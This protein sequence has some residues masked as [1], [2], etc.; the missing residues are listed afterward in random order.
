MRKRR[1]TPEITDI[2]WEVFCWSSFLKL[3]CMINHFKRKPFNH[4][5]HTP[6]PPQQHNTHTPSLNDVRRQ[7]LKIICSVSTKYRHPTTSL[8][9]QKRF[10]FVGCVV[11]HTHTYIAH[12]YFMHASIH[13]PTP[14]A[15]QISI[16]FSFKL[17]KK[18]PMNRNQR[19]ICARRYSSQN[20]CPLMSAAVTIFDRYL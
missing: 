4:P 9:S 17:S 6:S 16:P 3:V 11:A 13:R 15:W 12:H 20:T 19:I 8:S 18:V 10:K 5:K 1:K 7:D 14:S 2:S